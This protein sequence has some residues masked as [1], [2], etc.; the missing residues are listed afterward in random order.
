MKSFFNCGKKKV[1]VIEFLE[2]SKI[3]KVIR[4]IQQYMLFSRNSVESKTE[5]ELEFFLSKIR[6][7]YKHG[8]NIIMGV[9]TK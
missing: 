3:C 7:I 2:V 1:Q 5:I 9:I 4:S 6:G 8:L